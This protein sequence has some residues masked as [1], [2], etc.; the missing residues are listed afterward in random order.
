MA[1]FNW[2]DWSMS[3]SNGLLDLWAPSAVTKH[4]SLCSTKRWGELLICIIQCG[5]RRYNLHLLSQNRYNYAYSGELSDP[6]HLK[7]CHEIAVTKGSE[8]LEGWRS[9]A[10]FLFSL[11]ALSSLL[12]SE[13]SP[14]IQMAWRGKLSPAS[15]WSSNWDINSL[16]SGYCNNAE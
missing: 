3:R 1:A 11:E 14:P 13:K 12:A 6:H 9:M 16:N 15:N 10:P 5:P 4:G 2:S 8:C 7:A